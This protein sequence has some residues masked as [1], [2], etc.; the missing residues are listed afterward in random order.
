MAVKKPKDLLLYSTNTELAYRIAKEYY[1][2]SILPNVYI[3]FV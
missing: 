3:L 2:H 1:V